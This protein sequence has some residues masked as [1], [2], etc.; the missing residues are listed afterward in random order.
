MFQS[1]E[2][3]R[4]FDLDHGGHFDDL[5]LDDVDRHLL[6]DDLFDRHLHVDNLLD[7]LFD[8]DLDELFHDF[9]DFHFSIL[10]HNLK[11]TEMNYQT[12]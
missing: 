12:F 6:E 8:L 11:E 4:L 10:V 7:N 2:D 5:E 9:L 1:M 3:T